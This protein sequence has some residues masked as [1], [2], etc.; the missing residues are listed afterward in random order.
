[1]VLGGSLQLLG[2]SSGGVSSNPIWIPLY[3]LGLLQRSR[4]KFTLQIV[5]LAVL[6]S[7][8]FCPGEMQANISA[9]LNCITAL[10]L[11]NFAF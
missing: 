5:K 8:V 1:M 3:Q 11:M 10:F 4:S 9:T 2:N 7:D 6:A